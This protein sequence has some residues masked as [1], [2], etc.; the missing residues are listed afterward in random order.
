MLFD[1]EIV[2]GGE[3]VEITQITNLDGTPIAEDNWRRKLVGR[4]TLCWIAGGFY[5]RGAFFMGHLRIVNGV[6]LV[7]N[8]HSARWC[9]T[10]T[11]QPVEVEPD[12]FELKTNTS[13][14]RFRVLSGMESQ[15]VHAAIRKQVL[16][17]M[18]ACG[19]LPVFT[20]G[21]TIS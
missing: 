4:V 11:A 18:K 17:E 20:E 9:S 16:E 12:V 13:I 14:Y 8:R 1:N 7:V 19:N 2:P 15:L 21:N 3:W 5:R 6:V 10:T